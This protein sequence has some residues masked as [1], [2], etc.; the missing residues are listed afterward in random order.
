LGLLKNLQL[1]LDRHLFLA[2]EAEDPLARISRVLR[3]LVVLVAVLIEL[4]AGAWEL[5]LRQGSMA[6]LHLLL[7]LAFG[8]LVL[9]L[10]KRSD[11]KRVS[12]LLVVCCS[13]TTK[14]RRVELLCV[15]WPFFFEKG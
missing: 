9:V 7:A 11:G 2:G 4:L 10:H 3:V 5:Q 6:L 15:M 8:V 14:K 12:V 1:W 13:Y